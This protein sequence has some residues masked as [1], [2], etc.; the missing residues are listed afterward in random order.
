M[1]YAQKLLKLEKQKEALLKSATQEVY[2]NFFC[3]INIQPIQYLSSKNPKGVQKYG[4]NLQFEI[5]TVS[6]AT[7]QQFNSFEFTTRIELKKENIEYSHGLYS[8]VK[9]INP[10]GLFF[11]NNYGDFTDEQKN[12]QTE[13]V[14]AYYEKLQDPYDDW[15]VPR[16]ELNNVVGYVKLSSVDFTAKDF[17]KEI[18]KSVDSIVS[19]HVSK[20][21]VEKTEINFNKTE[22]YYDLKVQEKKELIKDIKKNLIS[23]LTNI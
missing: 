17:A 6:E 7:P 19:N 11:I 8:K 22:T 3:F 23:V 9:S 13:K 10:K 14:K 12:L 21:L 2:K 15:A 20:F 5:I 18:N 4:V 16:L 1:N